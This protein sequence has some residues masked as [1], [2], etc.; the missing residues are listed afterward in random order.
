MVTAGSRVTFTIREAAAALNMAERIIEGAIRQG[1]LLPDEQGR[2]SHQA[3]LAFLEEHA[4]RGAALR[5]II[6]VSED[7]GLYEPG[8][9]ERLE[10]LGILPSSDEDAL[11]ERH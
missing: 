8:I 4:R 11:S 2:L 3:L 5:E 6:Q 10:A 1:D 7:A 9:E